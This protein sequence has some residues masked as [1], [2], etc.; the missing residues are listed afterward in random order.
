MLFQGKMCYGHVLTVERAL[1][2]S[3]HWKSPSFNLSYLSISVKMF[4]GVTRAVLC[5]SGT[6]M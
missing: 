6:V 5:L 4:P 3:L 1:N 2:Y